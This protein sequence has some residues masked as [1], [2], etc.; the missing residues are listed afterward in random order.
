MCSDATKQSL[1]FSNNEFCSAAKWRFLLAFLIGKL[2]SPFAF[3][4]LILAKRDSNQ[5]P[6]AGFS[7]EKWN[8]GIFLTCSFDRIRI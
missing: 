8:E 5:G 3:R 4:P 7:E 2:R 6:E 1:L